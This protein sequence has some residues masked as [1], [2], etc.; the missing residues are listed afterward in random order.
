MNSAA[1]PS[2]ASQATD[3]R[4]L[5][6]ADWSVD[7]RAVA[8]CLRKR[9]ATSLAVL[10]PASLHGIDW[11][12][13]PYASVPC[14]RLAAAEIDDALTAAGVAVQSAEAGDHDPVAAILDALLDQPADELLVFDRR[15]RFGG[16]P[17]DLAH[18]AR[19]ATSVPVTAIALPP[20][21]TARPRHAWIRFRRGH[22]PASAPQAA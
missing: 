13:D 5:V 19:R 8:A 2:G 16:H 17:F 6:V 11:V 12:G 14:A 4:V 21:P 20:P 22:C 7:P 18:R 15:R 3:R 1:Q 10:V 9:P